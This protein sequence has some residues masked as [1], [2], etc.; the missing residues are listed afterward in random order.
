VRRVVV[1]SFNSSLVSLAAYVVERR[2]ER[3]ERC[4]GDIYSFGRG[5]GKGL[6]YVDRSFP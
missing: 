4:D 3:C 2:G 1:Q 5:K 6:K